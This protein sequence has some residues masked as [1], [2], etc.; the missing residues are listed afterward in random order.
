[1]HDRVISDNALHY[2]IPVVGV[3]FKKWNIDKLIFFNSLNVKKYDDTNNQKHD[4][5]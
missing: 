3:K 1:M 2:S 5:S 4:W